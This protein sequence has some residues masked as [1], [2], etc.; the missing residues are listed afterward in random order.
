MQALDLLQKCMGKLENIAFVNSFICANFNYCSLVLN[1][2]TFESTRKIEKIQKLCL[3]IVLDEYESDYDILLR[4]RGKVTMEIKQLR[5][6]AIEVFKTV[7]SLN[8]NYVID[9]FR[10]IYAKT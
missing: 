6:V 8:A 4:K 1:F 7:N 2:S 10:P 9:T 3:R 5:V